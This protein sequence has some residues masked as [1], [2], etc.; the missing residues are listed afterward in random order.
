[1]LLTTHYMEEADQL[2][3]RVAIMDHGHILALDTPRGLKASVGAD[4][5][6]RV[7]STAI[8]RRWPPCSPPGLAT[9]RGPRPATARSRCSS[10][11]ATACVPRDRG[12]RR[13]GRLCHH[14]PLGPRADARDRLHHPD[15]QGAARM[16]VVGASGETR[17]AMGFRPSR[18]A[19]LVAFW[20]LLPARPARPAEDDRRVRRAHDH[21][22]AAARLRVHL[23]VPQD[24]PGRGR[25]VPAR[26]RPS[27]RCS[28]PAWWRPR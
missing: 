4:T 28:W 22:A 9:A 5:I 24:R 1:M 13:V 7:S 25:L 21:A 15:R 12:A 27:R 6:V 20:A 10:R 19:S 3:D 8:W 2:C 23:R 14:R 11:A 18:A 26:R 17:R 16:S